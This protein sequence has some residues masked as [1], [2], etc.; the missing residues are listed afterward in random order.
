MP[1]DVSISVML[2]FCFFHYIILKDLNIVKECISSCMYVTHLILTG[3]ILLF[4]EIG[5]LNF[6]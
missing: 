6:Y 2:N 3:L 5:S 1:S 4:Y